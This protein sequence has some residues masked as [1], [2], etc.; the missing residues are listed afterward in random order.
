MKTLSLFV[1]FFIFFTADADAQILKKVERSAR[2]SAERT[3]ERRV[4]KE[5]AKKTDEVLD[6]VLDRQKKQKESGSRRVSGSSRTTQSNAGTQSG[7]DPELNYSGKV[8]FQDDFQPTR[9]GDFPRKVMSSGGGEIVETDDIKGLQFYPNSNILLQMKELPQNFA[10]EFDL[11]LEN[12]P[13]SLYRT[14]FNVYLQELNVL[15]H[16]DPK[17]KYGAVG[18]S[19]WGDKS[20]HQIDLFNKKAAYEIKEKIPYNINANV[21]DNRSK[22]TVLKHGN[23]LRL[24]INGSKVTDSPNLLQGVNVK[25][26]NFRLDGT[27]KEQGHAF[28][29]SA[30][31][32]TA[33]GED[34]RSQLIDKGNFSTSNI[35]FASGSDKIQPSSFKLLNEIAALI[36]TDPATFSIVGHTDSDGDENTNRSLSLQRAESVKKY[37]ISKGVSASKLQTVGRGES[38]PIAPNETE[39]GKA[40]NRRVQFTKK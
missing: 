34:L 26:I 18:F 17:N 39:E 3:I 40:R 33:I 12:V 6:E 24:F 4:E 36:R 8:I 35:L 25:H 13:S 21:I 7:I 11:I 5:S 20:D 27:K 28:V 31:K 22:W 2:R 10:L 37:L 23:R 14:A 19:L 32:V 16:N 15:K 1:T 30:V 9:L 38:H 29:I